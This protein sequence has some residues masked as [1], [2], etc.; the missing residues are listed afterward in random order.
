MSVPQV[1][2]EDLKQATAVHLENIQ[3]NI[4]RRLQVA[5]TQG[6][7]VLIHLLEAEREQVMA[8]RPPI[9]QLFAEFNLPT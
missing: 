3:R 7:Q 9:D 6:D 4:E 8:D 2:S 5:R 1:S